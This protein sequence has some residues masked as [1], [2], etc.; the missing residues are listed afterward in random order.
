MLLK[1]ELLDRMEI[2]FPD[3]LRLADLRR[4]YIDRDMASLFRLFANDYGDEAN[5]LR[6]AVMESNL[7]SIF[8]VFEG[9][10]KLEHRSNELLESGDLRKFILED[11]V[12]SLYRLLLDTHDT[13]I[14]KAIKSMHAADV[15]WDKDAMS[16]GQLKSKMW[17]IQ[18][19]RALDVKLGTVFLC[20]GWY[21][22]LATLL[23]EHEFD[24]TAIRSFDLDPAVAPIAEKFNLPWFSDNW[25]F[26]AITADIHDLNFESHSWTSWS[27]KNN[28]YSHPITESPDSVINTSCEHIEHFDD[29]YAKIPSGMLLVL[30]S[31]DFQDVQEH[32]NTSTDYNSF[33]DKTPMAEVLYGGELKLPAYSRFMRIGRK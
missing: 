18:E 17:L 12:W 31:N 20:A 11:N 25:K 3:S 32:V 15:Q 8:R 10:F 13:Q 26:K 14:V 19:L 9:G 21:G 22:I 5:E 28:R 29:W 1:T 4:A 23:F 27:A 24:I 33:A 16:Q 7:H 2:L 30:Q 6:K